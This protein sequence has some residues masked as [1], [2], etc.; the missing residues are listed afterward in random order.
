MK[1]SIIIG[2]YNRKKQLLYTL[3]TIKKSLYKN[4][5][6]IIIDDC[7]N[8]PDDMIYESDF[9]KYNIDIK[10]IKIISSEKTWINP[11]V[12]YNKGINLATGDIIILQNPEVCH[13]GDAISYV[14]NNL[15]AN[16][17][18]TLNCYGL[19]NFEENED[20]YKLND[21]I[22]IYN[23]INNLWKLNDYITYPGGNTAFNK[24]SIGGWLNHYLFHFVAYHYFGAIYKSDLID[25][26]NGGF[27]LDYSNVT[28]KNFFEKGFYII[29]ITLIEKGF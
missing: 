14:V 15:K 8:N 23:Y 27:D 17:W 28:I 29:G 22:L 24:G 3:E 19:N 26:M 21:P 2:Y 16:Q 1:I 25:K 4:I 7:T 9:I 11:C 5:E 6:V 12:C 10:L 20:I 13:I 18:L